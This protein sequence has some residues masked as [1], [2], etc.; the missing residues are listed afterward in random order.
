MRR[1]EPPAQT[2]FKPEDVNNPKAAVVLTQGARSS[3]VVRA[4]I[5]LDRQ[6]FSCGEIDGDFGSNLAKTVAAFQTAR[7]LPANGNVDTETWAALNQDTAPALTAYAITPQDVAGPFTKVPSEMMEQAALL[8]LNFQ[9]PQEALGEKFH[10]SPKLL[11][12]LN[13]GSRLDEPG[14]Q[15]QVPNVQMAAPGEAASLVVSK[16]ESSVIALDASG[17]VLVWYAATIGSEHDP[18]PLG[19]WKVKGVQRNPP[20]HYNP[21]LFWDASPIDQKALIKPG[22]NNPVGVVWIA[23][24]KEHYGIHGTPEPSDI[25]HTESHGCIRLT[26]WDAAELA[27]MVKPGTPALLKE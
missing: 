27:G 3:A 18:L 7:N 26:N 23:L 11:A 19:N 24:S 12:A 17:K 13:P 5:L 8:A 16:N 15:I 22:P 25:G 10:L 2:E 20:F 6:H 21:N 9:S 1:S 14:E 4:Q